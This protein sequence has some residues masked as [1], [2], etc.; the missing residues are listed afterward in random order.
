MKV[1]FSDFFPKVSQALSKCFSK[2][3]NWIISRI[4]WWIWKILF[5]FSSY[6]F[7]SM[8]EAK[9]RKVPFYRVQSFEITVCYLS[10]IFDHDLPLGLG[11]ESLT[12]L[13]LMQIL[14]YWKFLWKVKIFQ[15][16]SKYTKKCQNNFIYQKI[17]TC[18]RCILSGTT[19]DFLVKAVGY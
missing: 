10:K 14:R 12:F 18:G 16:R 2:W 3:I 17:K 11:K 9:I 4:P 8:W 1:P 13:K 19:S 15:L 5:V 7:L 6:E